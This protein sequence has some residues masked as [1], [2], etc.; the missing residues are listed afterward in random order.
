MGYTT[1]FVGQFDIS[2]PLQECH[3]AYLTKFSETRRM[4]R[5]E[6]VAM[7]MDD[8]VRKAADLPTGKE[9]KF[10]VGGLGSYGQGDDKSVVNHNEPPVGQPGLWC[11]WVPNSDGTAL[12]WNGVEKF[13]NYI[14]WL[15]YLINQFL[16]PW[17]YTVNGEVDW[18][19]E[20]L[21]DI[22]RIVVKDNFVST[23]ESRWD[24]A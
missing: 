18:R 9:G 19:G 20:E 24:D 6:I 16:K 8:P 15:K 2:P 10:F 17:G 1:D 14:T 5:N 3:K 13:Y 22:G 7:G 21:S 12:E 23:K 4:K 11:G